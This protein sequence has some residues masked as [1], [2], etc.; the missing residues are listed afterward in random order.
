MIKTENL[1]IKVLKLN[2][3]LPSPENLLNGSYP[4]GR[5]L[6]IIFR[7]K[8]LPKEAKSFLDFIRSEEG[9]KILKSNGYLPFN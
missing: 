2:G 5:E 7:E 9:R 3:L 4:L 1:N 6:S 8:T